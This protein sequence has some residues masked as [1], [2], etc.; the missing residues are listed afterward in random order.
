MENSERCI[1]TFAL[2]DQE[3][4]A[5]IENIPMNKELLERILMKC[6]KG[7]FIHEFETLVEKYPEMVEEI[8]TST[9]KE[10][11]KVIVSDSAIKRLDLYIN[12]FLKDN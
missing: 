6:I 10:I 1:L 8:L 3:L 9:E 2:E 4:E 5:Y 7:N 11:D 12:E